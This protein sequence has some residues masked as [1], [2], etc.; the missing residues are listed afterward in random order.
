MDVL[1][2]G[3]KR[4]RKARQIVLRPFECRQRHAFRTSFA[5]AWQFGKIADE[6]LKRYGI[7]DWH[8]GVWSVFQSRIDDAGMENLMNALDVRM[9]FQ[10]IE[11]VQRRSPHAVVVFLL[12]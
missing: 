2:D 6:A 12:F 7:G 9:G 3:S 8:G 10:G 4:V 5:D 1:T 11:L